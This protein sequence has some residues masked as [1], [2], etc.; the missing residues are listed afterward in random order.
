MALRSWKWSRL[1]G[2]EAL[3]ASAPHVSLEGPV[4]HPRPCRAPVSALGGG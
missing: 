2:R 4:C 1:G 3:S